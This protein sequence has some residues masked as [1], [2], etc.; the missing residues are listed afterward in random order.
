MYHFG[1]WDFV[2][3]RKD[4]D[5]RGTLMYSETPKDVPF[6][7]RRVYVLTNSQDMSERGHHAHRQLKQFMFALGGPYTINLDNGEVSETFTL[8]PAEKAVSIRGLVWRSLA[9]QAEN[10]TLVV[11]ASDIFIEDDYIRDYN[12]FRRIA[13]T[14]RTKG[15]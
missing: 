10:S 3:I 7:I 14:L 11:L 13:D 6:D 4:M 9:P 1:E 12:E 2:D 15:Q 5:Y 8:Y